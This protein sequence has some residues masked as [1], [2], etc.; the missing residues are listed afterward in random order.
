MILYAISGFGNYLIVLSTIRASIPSRLSEMRYRGNLN[1]SAPV[2]WTGI[3]NR[4]R[5]IASSTTWIT[6]PIF[7]KAAL[8]LAN[9]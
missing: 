3:L 6:L 9:L 1:P 7:V 4:E 8:L 2:A 5:S